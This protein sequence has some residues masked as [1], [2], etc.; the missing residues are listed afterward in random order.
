MA[1]IDTIKELLSAGT[2]PAG[3]DAKRF[4]KLLKR[5]NS[6][7][8][9]KFTALYTIRDVRYDDMT[10]RTYAFSVQGSEIDET[11]L[12]AVKEEVGA[13]PVGCIR[14]E[15]ADF[16]ARYMRFDGVTGQ[17]KWKPEDINDVQA[18]SD[19]FDGI[20]IFST[21]V[22][23]HKDLRLL[24]ADYI[25]YGN[26]DIFDKKPGDEYEHTV[27]PI[28]KIAIGRN[29]DVESLCAVPDEAVES[30]PKA[31]QVYVRIMQ[32][33]LYVAIAAGAVWYLFFR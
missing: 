8:D 15:S 13:L 24:D 10:Y 31:A 25:V 20:V 26:N 19:H 33:V 23:G 27:I 32:Y 5:Y 28:E 9:P 30:M 16:G 29:A 12:A 22:M 2:L 14:Y 1:E 17:Y 21:G 3:A 7:T 18:V 4:N 6:L 11:T